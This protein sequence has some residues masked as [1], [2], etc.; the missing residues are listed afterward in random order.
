MTVL[1]PNVSEFQTGSTTPN[2][3]GIKS[4]NGGAGII[5]VG[6]GDAH[7]DHMFVQNYTAMKANGFSFIG[8]YHYLV[9]GQDAAQ[10]AN[11]FCQWVGPRPRSPPA[12]CSSWTWKKEPGTRPAGR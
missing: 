7:L 6:Y 10:Q 8:L 2:W 4:Q 9:A 11:Q 5:R 1:L 12:P 3:A